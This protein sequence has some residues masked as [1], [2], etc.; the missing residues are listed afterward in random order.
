MAVDEGTLATARVKVLAD[1]RDLPDDVTKQ[2]QK[3][4][5]D[6][7]EKAGSSFGK[8]MTTAIA[9][10]LAVGAAIVGKKLVQGLKESV[11]A[12][13]DLNEITSKA[14]VIFGKG[15]KDIEKFAS[16]ADTALGQTKAQA[17]DAAS[18]FA[19]FG[20][21]ANLSGKELVK[22]SSGLVTTATDMASFSNTTPTEAIGA[23]GSALRGEFDPI[24]KYGVLLNQAS[25]QAEALSL[26]LLKGSVDVSKV[27]AAQLTAIVAQKRY[28]EAVKEHGKSSKEAQSAQAGLI[29]ANGR[30]KVAVSGSTQQL[31][32]Q[33]RV[34][35][36]NSL[37]YKQT[38]DAQGDFARTSAGLANQQ[39]ILTAQFT[40]L[41]TSIGQALLPVVLKMVTVLTS[42][43]LPTLQDLWAKNGPQVIRFLTDAANKFETFVGSID[44]DKIREWGNQL[45][46]TF[47][48]L[49]EQAGPAFE[50]IR[51]NIGPA[52]QSLK[53]NLI[54]ALKQ[55]RESGGHELADGLR[56]TGVVLK[57]LADHADLLGKLLPV[58]VTALVAWKVAQLGANI[59]A[60]ASPVIRLLEIQATKKQTAAIVANT[61]ARATETAVVEGGTVA[62][63]AGAAAENTSILAKTRAIAVSVAQKVATIATTAVTWLATAATTALGVAIKFATGPIGIIITVL[64]VLTAAVI[65]AY[66]HNETFRKIVDAVWKAIKTAIKAT[67]DW[68]VNTAW[69][70][71]KHIIDLQI[72]YY[73]FLWSVIKTVWNGIVATIKAVVDKIVALFN[74]VKN[75]ITVTIPNAFKAGVKAIGT[76]WQGLQELARKPVVFVVGVIN[77]LIGGYNKIASVFH[78]PTAPT[79]PGFAGGGRIPGSPS[80]VDNL[81]AEGPRG[82][83]IKLATG[84]YIVNAHRTARNLPLLNAINHGE[85]FADGGLF[86][87]IQKFFTDPAGYLK[88]FA[89]GFG[90]IAGKFGNSG[91]TKTLVGMGKQLLDSAVKTASQFFTK[92]SG[93]GGQMFGPWPSSPSAQR[94][95]SGVWRGIVALINSTGPISGSFGNAYRPGDPLW[96][97]SGRAVD[98]MGY[99][100]DLLATLLA[101]KGPLELIHRSNR[102]DYAY[103]RG[104]NKGSFNNALMEAHRNHVHIA[105]SQGGYYDSAMPPIR[106]YDMGGWW[107]SGTV[108]V[109]TSG[110]AEHV[111]TADARDDQIALLEKIAALLEELAPAVGHAVGRTMLGTVPAAQ[112]AGRMAG[113]RPR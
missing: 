50:Q 65:Y 14:S 85:G 25:V 58:L 54:P 99:N 69:P 34:L 9:A 5:E 91:L 37:I 20:K 8:R 26:G 111:T 92:V 61:A 107:P 15:A 21:G 113:K 4:L 87:T 83:H 10:S 100:Q 63:V 47:T 110:R 102:R 55:L 33:Q 79:I 1:A 41:K 97:G 16:T 66:K 6:A 62:T 38:K 36:V 43:V 19:V 2:T 71:I 96:H 101:V 13:S 56:V 76:I 7:G 90:N 11:S 17:L 52:G 82:E 77:K 39:R 68:F 44:G 40:N 86:G 81:M 46:A 104:K 109:N 70:F 48:T 23:I 108:G 12:A 80:D 95:D 106:K 94:G 112:T 29:N 51:A 60:A 49:R 35:A 42:K 32:S 88:G 103:T 64:A 105:F 98:W 27:K 73:K 53:D 89:G 3:G 74:T 31:T 24:E 59:A 45:K 57:F 78:A 18:T 75:F 22:F 28:N 72:Q 84:E 93:A 67:V 30:L